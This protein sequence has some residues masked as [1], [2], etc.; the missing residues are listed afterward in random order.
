MSFVVQSGGA[1]ATQSLIITTSAPTT[2]AIGVP[3]NQT[4]LTVNGSP[5]GTFIFVNTPGTLSIEVT[6]AG[7]AAQQLVSANISI[8][9]YGQ[10]ASQIYF[11]VALTVGAASLLSANPAVLAFTAVQGCPCGC[12]EF[13][14]GV[15][16]EQRG[17]VKL[18]R[19][20]VDAGRS[21]LGAYIQY[22]GR[23][24][25]LASFSGSGRSVEIGAGKLFRD[26]SGPERDDKRLGDNSG[27]ARGFGRLAHNSGAFHIGTAG[28]RCDV[29]WNL[30]EIR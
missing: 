12:P 4:W 26:D 16:H 30:E 19:N 15:H 27:N 18:Q 21:G 11:P 22:G 8:V 25:H 1:R 20:R 24:R 23:D 28:N 14:P 3:A 6:S 2:L 29:L 10:P 9:I 5:A 17:A 7:L 13:D